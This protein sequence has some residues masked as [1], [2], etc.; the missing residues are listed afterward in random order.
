MKTKLALPGNGIYLPPHHGMKRLTECEQPKRTDKNATFN[1]VA[2]PFDAGATLIKGQALAPY[3]IRKWLYQNEL[4]SSFHFNDCGD[5]I[6]RRDHIYDDLKK[7]ASQ[8]FKK[9]IPAV[10]F[11]GDHSITLPIIKGISAKRRKRLAIIQLD[12]HTDL[13][14]IR[15]GVKESHATW[16]Y[17]A[18][19]LIPRGNLI[20]IGIEKSAYPKEH[21]ERSL[22]VKQFWSNEINLKEIMDYLASR[23]IDEVYI[24]FDIDIIDVEYLKTTGAP[25]QSKISPHQIVPLLEEIG[26]KYKVCGTDFVEFTPSFYATVENLGDGLSHLV[27]KTVLN[28]LLNTL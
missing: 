1:M 5:L 26:G 22:G 4:L 6:I 2:I 14:K 8:L 20:Q 24:S 19:K 28:S 12:A 23:S 13:L 3:T 16:A 9:S 17:Y 15:D 10:F 27:T 25:S 21:W 7:I 18:S 11:G